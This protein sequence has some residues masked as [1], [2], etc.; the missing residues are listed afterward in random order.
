MSLRLGIVPFSRDKAVLSSVCLLSSFPLAWSQ[1]WLRRLWQEWDGGQGLSGRMTFTMLMLSQATW[2]L[3]LAPDA[4][5]CRWLAV[6]PRREPVSPA[7]GMG[8]I[9]HL[10]LP[11]C[12]RGSRTH[13]GATKVHFKLI[14]P[15]REEE[16]LGRKEP[17]WAVAKL[18][19]F[20]NTSIVS[21]LTKE[22][23]S[24]WCIWSLPLEMGEG[25]EMKVQ[26]YN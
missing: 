7:A 25:K 13:G 19:S 3:V 18:L 26:I 22:K 9:C 15:Q 21:P 24:K 1:R 16:I 23:R 10:Q 6:P 20:C 5:R 12:C 4:P 8:W 2:V 11:H 17:K 14:H